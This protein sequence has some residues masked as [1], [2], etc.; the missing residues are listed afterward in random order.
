MA[1]RFE[2][3]SWTFLHHVHYIQDNS[4]NWAHDVSMKIKKTKKKNK[5]CHF[6]VAQPLQSTEGTVFTL[7]NLSWQSV[8]S[9][10]IQAEVHRQPIQIVFLLTEGPCSTQTADNARIE[11]LSCSAGNNME[12]E[13]LSKLCTH[14]CSAGRS[15]RKKLVTRD[16]Q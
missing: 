2:L 10:I 15:K 3:F 13:K 7:C 14:G 16:W 12:L 1:E 8:R 5:S 6:Q 9:W 11:A 4:V